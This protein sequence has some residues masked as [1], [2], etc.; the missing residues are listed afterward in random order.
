MLV[1]GGFKYYVLF[2]DHYSNYLWIYPLHSKCEVFQKFIH[3][4]SYVNN[5]F[6]CDIVGFQCDHGC[7]FYN[8]NIAFKSDFL[9]Q[10]P[11]NKME[12]QNG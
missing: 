4:R 7:Q 9:A 5:Q 8:T 1:S 2:L 12:N 3:F 10:K 6:K 11:S